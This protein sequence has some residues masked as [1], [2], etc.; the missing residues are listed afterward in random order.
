MS[1]VE[2]SLARPRGQRHAHGRILR[3]ALGGQRLVVVVENPGD[4]QG[5]VQFEDGDVQIL[6]RGEFHLGPRGDLMEMRSEFG[7]DLV[8][9]D[10]QAR[11]SRRPALGLRRSQ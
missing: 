3:D 1:V 5:V 6:K 4:A 10:A 11:L 2:A 8:I 7:L 9:V